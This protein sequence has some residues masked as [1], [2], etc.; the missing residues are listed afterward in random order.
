MADK[1]DR[2]IRLHTVHMEDPSTATMTS[3]RLLMNLLKGHKREMASRQTP[4]GPTRK[5][6]GR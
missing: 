3:Q 2:A 4:K 1:L 5:F 6:G